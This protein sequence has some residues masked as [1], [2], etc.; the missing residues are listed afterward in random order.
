MALASYSEALASEAPTPCG[1][2]VAAV[3]ASLA[4]ALASMVVRVSQDRAAYQA[5][6]GL[7]E[8]ALAKS[9]ATRRRCLALAD[10]DAA[11]FNAYLA[12]RRLPREPRDRAIE[13]AAAIRD[14]A[15][16]ATNVPLAIVQ[17]CHRL[18]ELIERLAG[19]TNTHA[20]SDLDVA[21]L[22]LDAAARGAAAN[23]VANLDAVADA[24]FSDAVLAELDQRI[25]QT[26]KASARTREQVRKHRQRRPEAA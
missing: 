7:H 20:S 6:A 16:T 23:A 14:A 17:E 25:R 22:L 8:E 18:A 13:R 9:E 11:A 5:H 3:A 19:R 10:E 21:A 2:S 24:G 15:R 12:A 1:G 26:Q 4:A